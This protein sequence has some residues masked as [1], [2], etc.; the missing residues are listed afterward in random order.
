MVVEQ[1]DF[2]AIDPM[3]GITP[4]KP[5]GATKLKGDKI[6]LCW[7]SLLQDLKYNAHL[8]SESIAGLRRKQIPIVAATTTSLCVRICPANR[9]RLLEDISGRQQL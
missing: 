4:S 2:V 1:Q 3:D 5:T 7:L 9:N 8:P 6:T